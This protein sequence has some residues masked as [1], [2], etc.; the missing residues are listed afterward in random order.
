MDL[1]QLTPARGGR[2]S[3]ACN[4]RQAQVS[5]HARARRATCWFYGG[6]YGRSF[7]SRPRAAGDHFTKSLKFFLT[8]STHAR[9]RRATR[10][11]LLLPLVVRFQLTPARGGR[12]CRERIIRDGQVSTHARARRATFFSCTPSSPKIV[13]THARARRA[14]GSSEVSKGP[15]SFNSRPRAAGDQ[16]MPATCRA[17]RF[18]LT[19]ARGG[20][21]GGVQLAGTVFVSTHARARRATP[22]SDDESSGIEVSTHARARRATF[23]GVNDAVVYKVST[24]ARARRATVP[25]DPTRNRVGF[26]SRPR[27]AGDSQ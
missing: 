21:P 16:G 7:N 6:T 3:K 5:T 17:N 13:S 8:V 10:V 20:R 27:A 15:D 9:A 22:E 23:G 4:V 19:P 1:F 11:C 14:T 25:R 24:H 26:N 18:Q 2:R 12:L